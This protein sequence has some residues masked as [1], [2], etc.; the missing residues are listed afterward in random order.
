M[1][2]ACFLLRY[3][4]LRNLEVFC[5]DTLVSMVD[6]SESSLVLGPILALSESYAPVSNE[7][8]F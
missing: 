1:V 3:T 4:Q 2:C 8:S 6:V 7:V 5:G